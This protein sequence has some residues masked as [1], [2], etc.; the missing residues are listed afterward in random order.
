MAGGMASHD[1][2]SLAFHAQPYIG[3]IHECSEVDVCLTLA[4]T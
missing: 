3:P 4:E 2:F 1:A